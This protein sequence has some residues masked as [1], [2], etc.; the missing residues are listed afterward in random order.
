MKRHNQKPH[1]NHERWLVSY[2]DFI[3]LMFAFFVVLY[4]TSKADTRKQAQVAQ[5]INQAFKVLGLFEPTGSEHSAATSPDTPVTPVNIVLGDALSAAP[6]T[7]V[8]ADFE[9]MHRELQARLS[10]QIAEHVVAL[11]IGREGL[12]ISL[13]EAGFYDSGSTIPHPGS[14]GSIDSIVSLLRPAPYDI[15]IEGHTDNIPIHTSEFSSNWELSSGRA[16]RMARLF[17]EHFHF[18]PR[19]LSAAGYGEYHP[20]APNDTAEG[21]GQNRRVDIIVLP[22]INGIPQTASLNAPAEPQT[23]NPASESSTQQI[24]ASH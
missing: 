1:V 16:T 19:R 18:E 2:A 11:H 17:I 23:A 5:A 4:A 10:N 8:R 13:R 14:I 3:T 7:T 15:R 20:V 6:S 22:S 24:P 12:V 21:R 9:R